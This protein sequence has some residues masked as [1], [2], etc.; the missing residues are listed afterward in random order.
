MENF[1]ELVRLRRSTRKFTE[2]EIS[3]E[4]VKTIMETAL[5]APSSKRS[6]SWEFVLVEEKEKLEKLSVCKDNGA[7]LIAGAKLAVVVLG[8][9]A[10]SDVWIEDASIAATL[11]QLQAEE[12]GLGSCWVQIRDR[13]GENGESAEDFIRELLNIPLPMQ[14]LA[15]IALGHKAET[16]PPF[17]L[18]RAKWEKVHI[19][20]W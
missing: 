13:Y 16:K 12:L 15:V 7:K 4:E 8:D 3:P 5:M 14:V 20:Q 1:H 18:Q 2:E 9:P 10:K 19:G 11:I 17:D 6:L